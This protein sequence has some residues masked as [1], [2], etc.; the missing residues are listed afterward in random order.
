LLVALAGVGLLGRARRRAR[1][2]LLAMIAAIGG[3]YL[4]W[5]GSAFA[6]PGLRDGLGPHYH[7]GAL[8][9]VLILAAAG[10]RGLW[11]AAGSPRRVALA[12]P[13]AAGVLVVV[14]VAF[15][16]GSIPPKLRTQHWVNDNDALLDALL[17][18]HLRGPS[19]VIVTP[20]TPSRYTQVPYQTLRNGPDPRARL[21][22]AA[23]LG[24]RTATLPDRMPGRDLY[25]LR[26]EE[27]VD[28][29]APASYR[30][31]FTALHPLAARR[32]QLLVRAA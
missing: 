30:G 24:P 20:A 4:F 5:W 11:T 2:A 15:T 17:P 16:A 1:L 9:P 18:D 28:P 23:D 10:A 6:M 3:G 21:L 8:S 19:V 26:P 29:A 31:S 27:I 25:R 14:A 12:R 13:V 32:V 22:Y 7:L